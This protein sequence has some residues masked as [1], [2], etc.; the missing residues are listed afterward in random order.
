M[1]KT[2]LELAIPTLIMLRSSQ[3]Y[4]VVYYHKKMAGVLG[5]EPRYAEI[6]TQCL[7]A[8][9]YPNNLYLT[10]QQKVAG[11]LGFEPRYAE[12]KTQCLTAWRYPNRKLF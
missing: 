5:F 7:T 1:A 6:K 12:I 2:L 3:S 10:V 4:L 9:R 8:W 11:V